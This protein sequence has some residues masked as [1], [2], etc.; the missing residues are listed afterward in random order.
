MVPA[1]ADDAMVHEAHRRL[2][3]FVWRFGLGPSRAPPLLELDL[4]QPF[5]ADVFA[6]PR[7]SCPRYAA[8]DEALGWLL[9]ST[10]LSTEAH[11]K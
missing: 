1:D 3:D 8:D 7:R 4:G 2:A 6:L 9:A 5:G 10:A 11:S